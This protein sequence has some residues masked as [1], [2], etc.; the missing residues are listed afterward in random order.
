MASGCTRIMLLWQHLSE[1]PLCV[2]RMEYVATMASVFFFVPHPHVSCACIVT[3]NSAGAQATL[4]APDEPPALKRTPRI[5]SH[6]K[7]QCRPHT[8]H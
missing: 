7:T 8:A 1:A 5:R 6:H 2:R 3:Q 4:R